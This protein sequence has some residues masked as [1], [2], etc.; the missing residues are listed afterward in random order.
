MMTCCH[1]IVQLESIDCFES[2]GMPDK[3]VAARPAWIRGT[4][5]NRPVLPTLRT[6]FLNETLIY[7]RSKPKKR[8]AGGLSA[9]HARSAIDRQRHAGDEACLIGSQKQ[10]GVGDIPAGRRRIER[11]AGIVRPRQAFS[12]YY[13]CKLTFR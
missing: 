2:R 11:A 7:E 8:A 5:K 12:T 1:I 3:I 13:A 9:P 6:T 10:R 4:Q